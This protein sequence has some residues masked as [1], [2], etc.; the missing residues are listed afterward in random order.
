MRLDVK[1]P[2]T[3]S[4]RL[5]ARPAW[6][7]TRQT[8]RRA[9]LALRTER[10]PSRKRPPANVHDWHNMIGWKRPG[11]FASCVVQSRILSTK[12]SRRTCTANTGLPHVARDG[13]GG[14]APPE[15]LRGAP[16]AAANKGNRSITGQKATRKAACTT[17]AGDGMQCA[18]WR[19]QLR[20]GWHRA[21]KNRDY[22]NLWRMHCELVS[23]ICCVR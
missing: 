22:S 5:H 8:Y 11:S 7:G 6:Q 20:M 13:A 17:G 12:D 18:R 19:R 16:A 23:S 3:G 21:C 14:A 2:R 9:G 1:A 10:S 15:A 4:K